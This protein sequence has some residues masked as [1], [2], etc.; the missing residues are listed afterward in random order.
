MSQ[1]LVIDFRF[2]T[3]APKML[4]VRE[5]VLVGWTFEIEK[6]QHYQSLVETDVHF[7]WL[8]EVFKSGRSIDRVFPEVLAPLRTNR[9]SLIELAIDRA[10]SARR[11]VYEPLRRMHFDL[12]D[13]TRRVVNV[14]PDTDHSAR[15]PHGSVTRQSGR[16][17]SAHELSGSLQKP[18]RVGL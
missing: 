8:S 6:A 11:S 7:Q 9:F 13:I 14:I 2:C 12:R 1:F 18:R 16:E 3:G 5:N 17:P 4:M 15:A 10:D